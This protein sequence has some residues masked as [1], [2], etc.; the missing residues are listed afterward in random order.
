M[1]T[2]LWVSL[3]GWSSTLYGWIIFA[4]LITFGKVASWPS[5]NIEDHGSAFNAL[6]EK[7]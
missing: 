7:L 3:L 6:I 1:L 5:V 2:G 4:N